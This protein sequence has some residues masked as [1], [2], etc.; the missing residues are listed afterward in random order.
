MRCGVYIG[1]GIRVRNHCGTEPP[2]DTGPPGLGTTVGW[3]NRA[4]AS[5]VAADR[6]KAPARAAG[7]RFRGV[8]G[9]RTAASLPAET[10]A[11]SGVRCLAGPVPKVLVRSCGCSRAPPRPHGRGNNEKEGKENTAR[12]QPRTRQRRKEM[13]IKVTSVYVDDQ[14]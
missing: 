11:V 14:D 1:H 2:R 7:G 10:R 4:S 6:V 13:K 8:H 12:L 3:R 5:Y 9:G